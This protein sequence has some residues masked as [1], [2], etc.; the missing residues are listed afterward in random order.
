LLAILS[1]WRNWWRARDG[2]TAIEFA[3]VA[4]VLLLLMF[5]ILEF[6]IIMLVSNMMESATTVTSRLGRTGYA[7][8]DETREDTLLA[9]VRARTASML[10]PDQ[11][12]ITTKYY[13]QFDQVNRGEPW[14]DTNHNGTADPGEYTDINGNGHYDADLGTAG[15]GNAGDIVVYTVHYPW[16]IQ[17]PIMREILGDANGRFDITARAVVKNEPYDDE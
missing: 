15:Y 3:F 16:P 4:P 14:N 7:A 11:L 6:G 8:P 17:T 12:S 13:S 1:F 10:D 2:V 9:E 5:G